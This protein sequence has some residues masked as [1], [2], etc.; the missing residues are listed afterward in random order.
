MTEQKYK[1][2]STSMNKKQ[3]A[4]LGKILG[5]YYA[6]SG[7][8]VLD[9]GGGQFDTTTKY[10]EELGITNVIYD[11]YN[12]DGESNRKALG[13]N[14]YDFAMLSNVLNVIAEREVRLLI[15]ED[16][17]KHLRKGGTLL[18]KVYEGDG[19]GTLK[20]NKKR[21]SCQLNQKI[22]FYFWEVAAMFGAANTHFAS[23]Q[24]KKIIVAV[25]N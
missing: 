12:Q 13:K 22:R 1:S 18:I 17:K 9:Y 21:N 4:W 20:V 15:I 3:P 24:G 8:T 5:K 7:D 14:D 25:N 6:T 16:A 19:S 10:L 2:A 23:H 11:P